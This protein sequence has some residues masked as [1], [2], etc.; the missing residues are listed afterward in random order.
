M[1]VL[2]ELGVAVWRQGRPAEAEAIYRRAYQIE[3]DDFRVLNNLGLALYVLGKIDEAGDCYRRALRSQPK[4]FDTRMN[5]GIV[6]SDQGKFDDATVWLRAAQELRPDS[7]DILQNIG[8]NLGQQGRWLRT[9]DYYTQAV[10]WKPE[11]PETHRNL[12]SAL[13]ACGDYERGWPEY[14]WRLRCHAHP[15]YKIDRPFWNGD[16]LPD[17]TILLHAEQGYGDTLQFIRFA[18][19]VKRRV[20]RVLVLCPAQLLQLVAR[21]KGVDLAFDGGSYHPSC[22][23]R[24]PL[25][26]LPAILGTTLETVPSDVPYL[27]INKVLVDH[28]QA[29]LAKTIGTDSG[30]GA[31]AKEG[32]GLGQPSTRS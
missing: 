14:E 9:I 3:P 1:T 23:V 32:P 29:V 27:V 15:G 28:W 5:L 11:F 31:D 7:A 20:G 25:L 22:Q 18:S 4:V 2:N 17:A 19:M 26:S 30:H 12:A 13:L 6:L 21:C 16:N 24:A 10:R 8:M